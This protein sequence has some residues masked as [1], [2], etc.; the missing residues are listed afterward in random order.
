LESKAVYYTLVEQIDNAMLYY[1]N[2]C[3]SWDRAKSPLSSF[4]L[5]FFLSLS[6]FLFSLVV[7]VYVGFD[8]MFAS[9]GNSLRAKIT[10]V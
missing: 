4:F 6:F 8:R 3:P 5:S 2:T 1:H 9:L 10:R 7:E